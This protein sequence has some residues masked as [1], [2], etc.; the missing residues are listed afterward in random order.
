MD[1]AFRRI[2]LPL[3]ALLLGL[4]AVKAFV[5]SWA[6]IPPG[7]TGVR[8]NR[9]VARG[10][11]R[12]DTVTG[13][14]LYNPVQTQLI[15]YPTFIQRVVWTH[16]THEGNPLNEELTFNTKDSVPVNL[17]VAVSYRLDPAQVPSFYTKFRADRIETFTH[18]FLRDT[19]RNV[20]VAVGS[21]YTFDD[22]NG[23][24]KEEFLDRTARELNARLA[25]FGV[26]IQQFGLIGALRP[27]PALLEAVNAKTRAIQ[28]SIRA[29]NEVRMAQAEAKK[30]V[31]IAEG[32]A[33]ANR[34]LLLSL[35]AKLFE[36]ERLKLQ[37]EA[38]QKWNGA[39]PAV[40][41]GSGGGMLFNIPVQPSVPVR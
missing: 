40:L 4:I 10:I 14:V 16:D 35:D 32:E 21:E 7:Y 41:A 15:V 12:D 39:A 17:D 25:G 36:W 29:E 31:A 24:R 8:V 26:A 13:F 18:G 20:V 6:I 30:R 19:A 38:I 27:P 37:H 28:D 3:G 22:I 34:A 1:T 2:A 5:L 23:G 9:L 11:S 33:A